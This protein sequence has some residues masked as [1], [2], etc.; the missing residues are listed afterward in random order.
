MPIP[1]RR[2]ER[3]ATAKGLVHVA[4]V[5]VCLFAFASAAAYFDTGNEV[6]E[7]CTAPDK[8]SFAGFRSLF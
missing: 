6:Y 5:S 3:G 4:P 8:T 2:I 7:G 1:I